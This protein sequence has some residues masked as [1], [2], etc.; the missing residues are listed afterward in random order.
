MFPK[1]VR[2][3]AV[4]YTKEVGIYKKKFVTFFV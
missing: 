2:I 3:A 1:H 4:I